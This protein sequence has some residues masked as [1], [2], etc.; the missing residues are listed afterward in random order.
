[1]RNVSNDW[2]DVSDASN[3]CDEIDANAVS[4][5]CDERRNGLFAVVRLELTVYK[6]GPADVQSRTMHTVLK[7]TMQTV[8]TAACLRLALRVA[9]CPATR[10]VYAPETCRR[11]YRSRLHRT[12]GITTLRAEE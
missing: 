6:V 2:S 10:R 5:A 7:A 3:A 4:D 9:T 8:L 11:F 1:M 12:G